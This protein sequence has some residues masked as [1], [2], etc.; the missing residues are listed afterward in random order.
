MDLG[1]GGGGGSKCLSQFILETVHPTW[2]LDVE[3]EGKGRELKGD[4]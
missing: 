2:Q 1:H 4:P 3:H